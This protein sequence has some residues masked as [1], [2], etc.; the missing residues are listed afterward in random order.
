MVTLTERASLETELKKILADLGGKGTI[1]QILSKM[2]HKTS[3]QNVRKGL[4]RLVERGEVIK[5]DWTKPPEVL[6]YLTG[7]P[8]DRWIKESHDAQS[9]E[10]AKT[11]DEKKEG[12]LLEII[13]K[14]LAG[15]D[16][17]KMKEVFGEAAKRLM[18]ED[19]RELYVRFAQ[20]LRDEHEK[21]V[22]EFKKVVAVGAISAADEDRIMGKIEKLQD[23]VER[24]YLYQ[25][26]VP[27][28]PQKAVLRLHFSRKKPQE[29]VSYIDP[30]AVRQQLSK[31]ILGKSLIEKI[32][33]SPPRRAYFE[34]GTDA[35]VQEFSLG[36]IL[37]GIFE[38]HPMAIIAAVVAY[39]DL[40]ENRLD[41]YDARP[42]PSTWATY[43]AKEARELGIIIPPD[44]WLQLDDPLRWQR[45]VGAAMNV[46]QYMKDHEALIGRGEKHVSIVFR[47]GRI[48]P[49]E[50]LFSDYHQGRIH[51]EMVR[52]SL[53]QFSNTLKDVEYSD[54]ALY[55]GVVKTAVVEVIAPMLFWYLKYGSASEGRKAIWPDMD[56]EK[57]YGFRMSDQKTVMTLFEAL[58]QELDKDEF[59]VTCRFVRHFW[60]MSGMAKEFTEAGL[61]IDSNEEAWIDFIGKEIEKKDLTFE[62]E[63]E[64]YALLCSRAAVMSFYCTPPK[65]S[66][67][68]L[69]LSTSGL[70]LPR[71]EVLL[72]YRYLRK[73]A[74]LQSKAQEYVERVLEALADPRTLD[75]YPE[76]IYK[77]NVARPLVPWAVCRSHEFIKDTTK[78]YKEDFRGYMLRLAIVVAREELR[79]R[80]GLLPGS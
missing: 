59:L 19:P 73:P 45:T 32:K 65:S 77:Q 79:K 30:M 46:R 78:V 66:T 41:D 53:K 1:P 5:D 3:Y 44:A 57:I 60:F 70:A 2:V 15:I 56:E 7:I 31:V 50:H 4:E 58:L 18:K 33:A 13:R 37:P 61:G 72:P 40:F 27:T 68:V 47:D 8:I 64:T 43:T 16:P 35:S 6:Y 10:E 62:L 28:G 52:N 14:E 23:M 51:G 80:R 11:E 22:N 76:S 24:I 74:D 12:F 69:S 63:P 39:Y 38:P 26:G 36:E 75:I 21:S 55:C 25:F 34:A 17:E 20:W 67:Y 9:I 49:L 42:D 71:Y 54:R 29:A 48:F